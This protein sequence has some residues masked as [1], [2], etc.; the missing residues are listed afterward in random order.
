[1]CSNRSLEIN[2]LQG[3][4]RREIG[5]QVSEEVKAVTQGEAEDGE[6]LWAE[7]CH[8]SVLLFHPRSPKCFGKNGCCRACP[9]ALRR[10]RKSGGG[11]LRR[12]N[13]ESNNLK[14]TF[15]G[16]WFPAQRPQAVVLQCSNHYCPLGG[17][18]NAVT[19]YLVI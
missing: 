18:L 7:R 11:S 12:M 6:V 3:L 1:M 15:R 14:I 17:L 19:L 13:S 5:S 4:G 2:P 16:R 10:R 8:Q 9:L